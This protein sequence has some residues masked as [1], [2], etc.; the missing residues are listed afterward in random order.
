MN[1]LVVEENKGELSALAET[2][3]RSGHGVR[4]VHVSAVGGVVTA[5][6]PDITVVACTDPASSLAPIAEALRG[7]DDLAYRLLLAVVSSD[8][9]EARSA[10]YDAGADDVALSS[11]SPRE[12]ADH[13]R[14]AER[15]V[16]L[17][18]RLRER[19]V[20][21][22][23]ALRRLAL[24]ANVR[25]QGVAPVVSAPN[26]G[27]L[28]LLLTQA[29]TQVD[30]ILRSMCSEYLQSD[31]EQVVGSAVLPRDCMGATISLTDV[32]NE[33]SLELAFLVPPDAARSIAEMFTGDPSL[34]DDDVTKDVIL[35]LANSGMGAVR[36][37]FLS[38]EFRFA[39]STPKVLTGRIDK[40]LDRAE[41]KRTLT[42]RRGAAAVHVVVAVR[43]QGRT[44]VC[45]SRLREGMVIASDV[46]TPAGVLL[47][48]AGTRLT[49]TAAE[50]IARL[51]PKAEVELAAD[52]EAA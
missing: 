21:L 9:S 43:H 20:E 14:S 39:A 23:S 47:V 16:R 38:E 49:E 45:G 11:A 52:D 41:A 25:A 22:E 3:L 44:K 18:R 12:M 24:A 4:I 17:E 31:Y 34:V 13:I 1:I 6:K 2:L 32:E 26:R 37:A 8:T 19:V 7:F 5:E 28:R 48:R 27:G 50:K 10:A 42:F 15:I 40:L 36:A 29:W 51:L 46:T 33:L 30:D 35:E